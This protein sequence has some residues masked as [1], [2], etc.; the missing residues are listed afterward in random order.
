MLA[1]GLLSVTL[2]QIVQ[3]DQSLLSALFGQAAI[4]DMVNE[5]MKKEFM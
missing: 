1:L 2:V 3:A 4:K 5:I